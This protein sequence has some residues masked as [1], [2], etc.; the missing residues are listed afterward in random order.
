MLSSLWEGGDQRLFLPSQ[1]SLGT[2]TGLSVLFCGQ[3]SLLRLHLGALPSP[4]SACG[5]RNGLQGFFTG[6]SHTHLLEQSAQE[7]ECAEESQGSFVW[8]QAQP[9]E[10]CPVSPHLC[11]C[12]PVFEYQTGVRS[13]Y[14]LF[15][16]C[17]RFSCSSSIS[18][19]KILGKLPWEWWG[20][21]KPGLIMDV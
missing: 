15:R 5:Q 18:W 17:L 11:M 20:K 6:S 13:C 9:K 14:C 21:W 7:S 12:F 10:C 19:C 8:S 3:P 4:P 1:Q 2:S 16:C